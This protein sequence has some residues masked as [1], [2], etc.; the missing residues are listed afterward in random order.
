MRFLKQIDRETPRDL[1]MHLIADN[2]ATHKYAAVREWL[3]RRPR[4]V[5]S[6]RSRTGCARFR[7]GRL[8]VPPIQ[9][10]VMRFRRRQR[11]HDNQ[12]CET[13]EFVTRKGRANLVGFWKEPEPSH[14]S[15]QPACTYYKTNCRGLRR[16]AIAATAAAPSGQAY[17][18]VRGDQR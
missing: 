5:T 3:A 14:E 11:R 15:R 2:Y 13:E 12:T 1:T 10:G 18:D 4:L 8:S 16:A 6:A 7:D 9:H 17:K